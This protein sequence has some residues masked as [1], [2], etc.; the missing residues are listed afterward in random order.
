MRLEIQMP[1]ISEHVNIPSL[2]DLHFSFYSINAHEIK[3][4][5]LFLSAIAQ[6]ERRYVKSKLD[7]V[8]IECG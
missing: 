2:N 5:T 8:S 1:K 7:A 6:N 4:C 3:N